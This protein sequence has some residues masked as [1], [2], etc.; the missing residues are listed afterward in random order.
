MIDGTNLHLFRTNTESI[1]LKLSSLSA[2]AGKFYYT[3][4]I[5]AALGRK[6]EATRRFLN[7]NQPRNILH[8]ELE[9]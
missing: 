5:I 7:G 6:G 3:G 1:I 8:Y 4:N 2:N 9:S